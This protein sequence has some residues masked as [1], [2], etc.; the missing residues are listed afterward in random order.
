MSYLGTP[1]DSRYINTD[2]VDHDDNYD[3]SV[4]SLVGSN[5]E[6]LEQIK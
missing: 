5:V 1:N 3:T 2:D 6:K 4:F